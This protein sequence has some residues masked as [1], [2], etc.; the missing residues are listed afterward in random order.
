MLINRAYKTELNPNNKQRSIFN[1]YA[2]AARYV[3]N[4]ALALRIAEYEKKKADKDYKLSVSKYDLQKRMTQYKK[5][6]ENMWLK[7]IPIGVREGAIESLDR[8][9][10]NFFR[11]VK[12]GK[13]KA[14]FPK[15]KNR[16][17]R[18]SFRFRLSIKV[19][20]RMIRLPIIG[21]ICLKENGY[22]PS[23]EDV[24]I[25]FATVSE[26]ARRWYV[27]VTVETEIP[28]PIPA[29]GEAIGVDVGIKSLAVCSDGTVYENPKRFEK[30]RKK[31]KRLQKKQSRQR[32]RCPG[33]FSSSIRFKKGGWC[34]C[35][36]CENK[37]RIGEPSKNFLKTKAKIAKIQK[38]I[39]D[40]RKNN[41]HETTTSII[42]KEASVIVLEDLNVKGMISAGGNRKRGLNRNMADAGMGEIHRQLKY[43]AEW[44]GNEILEAPKFFPSSK[45]CNRC[46]F[47]KM[48]LELKD[49]KWQCESCGSVNDRDFNA[50]LNLRDLAIKSTDMSSESKAYGESVSPDG[51]CRKSGSSRGSRKPVS[52]NLES[53]SGRGISNDADYLKIPC[54]APV[55]TR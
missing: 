4:W 31:L 5:L 42:R 11:H 7:E 50:S 28:N 38:S 30:M 45:T 9:Y 17:S 54:T 25:C 41:Q 15:F 19:Y 22:L 53:E 20:N 23:H 40:A 52:R 35:C 51:L 24:K 12:E 43:K 36:K 39:S 13:E 14:G 29:N 48:D 10:Q 32:S 18:K 49:R 26:E 27:S 46:G 47:V 16:Q 33:C 1:R 37:Y 6:P 2:G 55:V 8:A 34:E 3:Y 44:N 21:K